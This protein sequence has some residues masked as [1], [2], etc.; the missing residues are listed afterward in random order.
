MNQHIVRRSIALM[1]PAALLASLALASVAATATA[2][3]DERECTMHGT[4]GDDVVV[5]VPAG[6][7]YCGHQGNDRVDGIQGVFVGGPGD[8]SLRWNDGAFFG[9]PGSDS[10]TDNWKPFYGGPGND[11]VTYNHG[12][13]N[14]GAF[15]GGP[16]FDSVLSMSPWGEGVFVPGPQKPQ[17]K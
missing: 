12:G 2:D 4:K 15:F 13:G 8:D 7:V 10:V 5:Y 14:A 16:G 6:E 3:G 1:A 11:S 17:K 9:G